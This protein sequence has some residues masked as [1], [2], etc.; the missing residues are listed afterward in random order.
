MSCV[1]LIYIYLGGTETSL[2][3]GLFTVFYIHAFLDS[4]HSICMNSTA[5]DIVNCCLGYCEMLCICPNE[6]TYLGSSFLCLTECSA[7]DE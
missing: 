1:V 5:L 4:F 2:I 3:D 7:R 6:F